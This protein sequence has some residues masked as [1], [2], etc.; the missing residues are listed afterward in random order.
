MAEICWLVYLMASYTINYGLA[1]FLLDTTMKEVNSS[2]KYVIIWW[3]SQQKAPKRTDGYFCEVL[4]LWEKH[5]NKMKCM[6]SDFK[7]GSDVESKFLTFFWMVQEVVMQKNF[8][9]FQ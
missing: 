3:E 2:P 1:L 5:S 7:G 6:N 4:G 8:Y 9:K